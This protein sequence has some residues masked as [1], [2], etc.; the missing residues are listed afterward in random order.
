MTQKLGRNRYR[1]ELIAEFDHLFPPSLFYGLPQHKNE[2]WTA[3]KVV[4]MSLIMF[5]VSGKTLDEQ[6]SSARRIVKFLRPHWKVPVSYSGFVA[7]QVR[8]WPLVRWLL[9][10]RLRLQLGAAE[11]TAESLPAPLRARYI[12]PDGRLHGAIGRGDGRRRF[13]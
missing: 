11:V 3:R 5:W 2:D 10:S 13:S 6:F 9:I 7:A 4:W 8:W 1:R 12:A